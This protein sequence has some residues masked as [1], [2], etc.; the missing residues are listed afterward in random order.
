MAHDDSV[1]R[2]RDLRDVL[3]WLG[4][5]VSGARCPGTLDGHCSIGCR[6]DRHSVPLSGHARTFGFRDA[7]G[8]VVEDRV[9]VAA[10]GRIAA[11]LDCSSPRIE[12]SVG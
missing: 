8:T 4:V 10:S 11:A 7:A 5:G 3:A 1:D 12:R 9:R 6:I 2:A